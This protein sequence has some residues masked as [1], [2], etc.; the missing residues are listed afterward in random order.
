M[1]AYPL[2]ALGAFLEIYYY[3]WRFTQDGIP[4]VLAIVSGVALTVFLVALSVHGP[5]W[6]F[7]AVVAFSVITTSSG[8]HAALGEEGRRQATEDAR[9]LAQGDT[10][11][12]LERELDMLEESVAGYKE[13]SS[14]WAQREY[15]DA[16]EKA[17]AKN[18]ADKGRIR[19]IGIQ[20][21]TLRGETVAIVPRETVYQYYSKV[22]G[23][24]TD[25]IQIALQ[26]LLSSFFAL[27]APIGMRMLK[28][29]QKVD[30]SP[31]VE[32]WWDASMV[33]WKAG[34]GRL[35]PMSSVVEF[36]KGRI[37]EEQ[38][39]TI[40]QAAVKAGV[41]KDEAPVIEDRGE[42]MKMII[43]ALNGK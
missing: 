35:S 9:A 16:L 17:R 6:L 42:A 24:S 8:Q 25:W 4:L 11:A 40:R 27:M 23:L 2:I 37:T 28:P 12:D 18:E 34:K 41:V 31:L 30:W 1:L 13:P 22:T 38:F 29:G 33:P 21:R 3:S 7:F 32:F 14:L 39:Q 43:K 5:K 36:G 15:S 26:T 10:V 19:E 20:L